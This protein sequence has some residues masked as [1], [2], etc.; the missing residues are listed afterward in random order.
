MGGGFVLDA[1][2][3]DDGDVAIYPGAS[4]VCDAADNDCDGLTDEGGVCALDV[5]ERRIP[6]R[7]AL[8]PTH[9]NPFRGKTT[10]HFDLPADARVTLEVFDIGGRRVAQLVNGHVPAGQHTVEFDASGLGGGL[11][12]YRMRAAGEDGSGYAQTRKVLLIP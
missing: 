11:Y 1:S 4:E 8:E 9:P 5:E 10:L 6:E 12:F 3:C 2:D 7:F